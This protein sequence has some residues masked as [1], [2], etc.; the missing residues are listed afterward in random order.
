MTTTE[1][2]TSVEIG[3]QL[4]RLLYTA[5]TS[6][7]RWPGGRPTQDEV[8]ARSGCT[9]VWYR[10]IE[11]GGVSSASLGTLLDICQVLGIDPAALRILGYDDVAEALEVR[12]EVNHQIVV[13][14]DEMARVLDEAE[15]LALEI[16]LAKTAGF[17]ARRTKHV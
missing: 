11:N 8:G 12:Y 3:P 9:S 1:F 4:R 15:Q 14:L 7:E 2:R 16:I 13:D 5:R 6:P 17:R 10:K